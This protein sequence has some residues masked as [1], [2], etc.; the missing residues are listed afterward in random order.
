MSNFSAQDVPDVPSDQSSRTHRRKLRPLIITMGGQRQSHLTEMFAH[1]RLA[2]H[3][4]PPAFSPGVPARSIR[5]CRNL[6][7]AAHKAGLLPEAEWEALSTTG[8]RLC[9][10]N[11]NNPVCYL[12]ALTDPTRPGSS[13][14]PC[15]NPA[16][17]VAPGRKGSER[18]R[19][20]HYSVEL[21]WKSKSISR[22]RAVLAC[23]LAHLSAMRT[24]VDGGYDFILEDNV[25]APIFGPHDDEGEEDMDA[26]MYCECAERIWAT[27]EASER[28]SRFE[29]SLSTTQ[30][31]EESAASGSKECHL[32]YYGWLGSRPN[33]QWLFDKHSKRMR[34]R[35][36]WDD[37]HGGASQS[38]VFPYPTL[39]EF[40]GDKPVPKQT[41]RREGKEKKDQNDPEEAEEEEEKGS[42]TPVWGCYAYS[43]SRPGYESLLS[44]LRNDVGAIL[45]R[46]K[47][48]PSYLVKPIDRVLPRRI[49]ERFGRDAVHVAALPAFFR[50]PMLKSTIHSQ[51]DVEFCKSTEYQ[52]AVAGRNVGRVDGDDAGGGSNSEQTEKACRRRRRRWKPLGWESLWLTDD[53]KKVIAQR[54]EVG[55]W[56][57]VETQTM[58]NRRN[59]QPRKSSGK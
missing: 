22:E 50:A 39:E 13:Q 51:L 24:L 7:A 26:D 58:D 12:D 32:R 23:L 1:P 45:W 18:D 41:K 53:E 57:F 9:E 34:A 10:E 55:D 40:R 44:D 54:I 2:A 19:K 49:M 33:L 21:W 29:A 14:R 38:A 4:E 46:G 17:P 31:G 52:M 35:E 3:F 5:S 42:G 11:N 36:E 37:G 16:V 30:E 28:M 59:K 48:M 15:P 8:V 20:L 27:M 25:R 6:L 56:S 43:V 47:A